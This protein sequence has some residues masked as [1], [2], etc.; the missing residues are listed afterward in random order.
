VHH[1]LAGYHYQPL[2]R[3][4]QC[5]V[6]ALHAGVEV[7][8]TAEAVGAADGGAVDDNVGL[9]SLRTEDRQAERV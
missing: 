9:F 1:R 8:P 2:L 3:T 4:G 6:G 5:H 7:C